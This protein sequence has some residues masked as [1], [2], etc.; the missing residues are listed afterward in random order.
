MGGGDGGDGGD[1]GIMA[2]APNQGI[3]P[4]EA[5]VEAGVGG[6]GGAGASGGERRGGKGRQA[7]VE[8]AKERI[9]RERAA[10]G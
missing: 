2:D 4:A 10:G 9:K 3:C 5:A 6:D 8:V 7:T 1:G